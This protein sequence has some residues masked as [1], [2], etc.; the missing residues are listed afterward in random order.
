QAEDAQTRRPRTWRELAALVGRPDLE[1]APVQGA[2]QECGPG[3]AWQSAL[4]HVLGDS[5]EIWA[6]RA[7]VLRQQSALQREQ[8][9][10]IP[11]WQLQGGPQYDFASAKVQAQ[12]QVGVRLPLFDKNQGNVRAARGE[13][14]HARAEVARVEL[15]LRQRLA[16]AFG[17]YQ[18]ARS[19][20]RQYR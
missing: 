11:T 14:A 20:A 7:R 4:A 9:E 6:A 1:P 16:T 5:P 8:V 3:L 10:P 13:L 2:L 19:D 17:Q 15:S 18:S 12:V